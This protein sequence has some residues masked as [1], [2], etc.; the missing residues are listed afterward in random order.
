MRN[1]RW[2]LVLLAVAMSL[3]FM[4]QERDMIKLLHAEV[5]E[6]DISVVEAQRLIGK[7][8][9]EHQGAVMRCD[10]AWLYENENRVEAFGHVNIVQGDSLFL[11]GDKL[12]YNGD[13]NI[14]EL[15][16]NIRLRDQD[17]TLTTDYLKYNT[18]TKVAT[19]L[20][21]GKIVSAENNNTLTSKMGHYFATSRTLHFKDSVILV[22]PKYNMH[23]D[24]LQYNMLSEVAYFLGPTT[25][26]S[27]QD[28]IYCENG[29]YDTNLEIAQFNDN[30]QLSSDGQLLNGD[31]LYYERK[32]AFGEA[33]GAVSIADT[34]NNLV[35]TGD[36]GKYLEVQDVSFVTGRALFQ[37]IMEGDTLHLHADTLMS[38]P[39]TL[40]KRSIYAYRQVKFY[41]SDMQGA[42]DSLV[43]SER[44]SL[45]EMFVDPVVWSEQN[46]I[47]GDK[48]EVKTYDNKVDQ[49]YCK[50]NAFL[51]SE[52]AGHPYHNQIK[53]KN[54]TGYFNKN[55]LY[56]VDFMGNGE[57]IY[58]AVD[59]SDSTITGVN[60]STC[61]NIEIRI[62]E[63][64]IKKVNFKMQPNSAFYPMHMLK[65]DDLKLKNFR[66]DE[67]RRPLTSQDI[68]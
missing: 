67:S 38:A 63:R 52:V 16:E 32:A 24:T 15:F 12:D 66:W 17:M 36:Y 2:I 45:F 42:C 6:Y 48:I 53:G 7:V 10:S 26:T 61:A 62:Q 30:A 60:K 28:E 1:F 58:F 68:F 49:L 43:Y 19:Y 50:G 27:K 46:Q 8:K 55:D 39:D 14:A 22:N 13:E 9:F 4:A 47:T 41:K 51:V 59:D 57:A 54:M 64:E 11:N 29:W 18:E 23:T 20:E 35:I 40:Q 65:P 5:S 33:F 31:S 37:Q 3:P 25:I 21:G 56:R 34:V 44:D